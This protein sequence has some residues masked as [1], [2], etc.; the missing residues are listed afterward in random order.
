VETTAPYGVKLI[1]AG[2]TAGG[3]PNP[4]QL[5]TLVGGE[6]QD[7]D[8][9]LPVLNEFSK[10]VLH[11]GPSG[12]GMAT[13][14]AR[15]IIVYG[16][17]RVVYESGLL[18]EAA[19]V[20]LQQLAQAVQTSD[21]HGTLSTY[22]LTHRGTVKPHPED[23]KAATARAHALARLWH[24]DLQA[25]LELGHELGVTLPLTA[26]VDSVGEWVLGLGA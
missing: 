2:V 15:N 16:V 6:K 11:M 1:D 10:L 22:W 21:P 14:I 18:A 8:N 9:I 13:K 5:V 17:W 23:A 7:V 12:A 25:A 24:K 26:E 19:G 20:D 4:G 3:N